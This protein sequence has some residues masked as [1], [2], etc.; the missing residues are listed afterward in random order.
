MELKDL[1]NKE[2]KLT[3][4]VTTETPEQQAENE[5]LAAEA[6]KKIKEI[7]PQ[8]D[9]CGPRVELVDST[10]KYMP[11]T[12]T[13]YIDDHRILLLS[14][15]NISWDAQDVPLAKVTLSFYTNQIKML[16]KKT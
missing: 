5:K 7:L 12:T 15:F 14:S 9:L 6:R 11:D 8:V 16:D 3:V 10:G 1:E 13:I 4:Q 2:L